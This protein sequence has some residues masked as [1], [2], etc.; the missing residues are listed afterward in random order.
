MKRFLL[1]LCAG[2]MGI[3]CGIIMENMGTVLGATDMN[4]VDISATRYISETVEMSGN[5]CTDL[6]S[7]EDVFVIENGGELRLKDVTLSSKVDTKLGNVFLV[8][9]GGVLVLENVTLDISIKANY[10]IR[11]EGCIELDNVNFPSGITRS[12]YNLSN[13]ESSFKLITAYFA[14]GVELAKGY[15]SVL[16]TTQITSDIN[17][18][19]WSGDEGL[20]LKGYGKNV[21]AN[22]YIDYINIV[23]LDGDNFRLDYIAD[24]V[25]EDAKDKQ[26]NILSAGDIV[27]VSHTDVD[28][29][30]NKS[31]KLQDGYCTANYLYNNLE[32]KSM[33]ISNYNSTIYLNNFECIKSG[34]YFLK[35]PGEVNLTIYTTVEGNNV[36]SKKYTYAS[37]L[38]WAVFVDIPEGYSAEHMEVCI[39]G[40]GLKVSEDKYANSR[41]LRPVIE[42]ASDGEEYITVDITFNFKTP[43][44]VGNICIEKENNVE[45]EYSDI[46]VGESQTFTITKSEDCN[47][48][49]V[50]FN[51]SEIECSIDGNKYIFTS[52]ASRENTLQILSVTNV[53]IVPETMELYYGEDILLGRNYLVS[54][55]GE[56]I[57]IQ[58]IGD[59]NMSAGVHRITGVV[60]NN[61]KYNVSLADGEYTY[62]INPKEISIKDIPY[63]NCIEREYDENLR[64]SSEMFVE[65]P[66]YI[67]CTATLV[68]NT[69]TLGKQDVLLTFAVRDTNYTLKEQNT[70]VT[71]TLVITPKSID[72]NHCTFACL[73]FEYS[74]A[75]HSVRV[76]GLDDGLTAQISYG[77][78][79]P[80]DAGDYA[81]T[82]VITATNNLYSC[83]KTLTGIMHIRQKTVAISLVDRDIEYTGSIPHLECNVD[84]VVNG[85]SVEVLLEGIS[86]IDVEDYKVNVL[87]L[88]NANYCTDIE[89][90]EYSII[91]ADIDMTSVKFTDVSTEYDGK[92]H[93]PVLAG[94]LP[95]GI[96]AYVEERECIDADTY[97]VA[98]TFVTNKNYTT[99]DTMYARVEISPR[100]I[101]VVFE[102]PDNLVFDGTKKEVYISFTRTLTPNIQ[103][104][105]SYSGDCILAGTY[106]CTVTLPQNSNYKIVSPNT[107]TFAIYSPR[108]SYV[109]EEINFVVEGK[110]HPDRAVNILDTTSSLKT[111]GMVADMP[112]RNYTGI[113]V[114]CEDTQLMQVT[115]RTYKVSNYSNLRLYTINNG[116]LELIDY[117][118]EN[119]TIHFSITGSQ[120]ILLVELKDKSPILK[121]LL[122]SLSVL[123]LSSVVAI[124]IV[125]SKKKRRVVEKFIEVEE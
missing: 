116:K 92:N 17:I 85:D 55:T 111:A 102:E 53:T 27:I 24:D 32:D 103:Y 81:V 101:S 84:G 4:E 113:E 52:V 57:N 65:L 49:K 6:Q 109:S 48:L 59:G 76:L 58:Y 37:M 88:S 12:V 118:L 21:F 124:C 9:S 117:T 1:G 73:D 121:I 50:I 91:P 98:C 62:V 8:K 86:S 47:I 79:T 100:E 82:A 125:R 38:D 10:G 75:Q 66:E 94:T 96:T 105:V 36:S 69:L 93:L 97:I 95:T 67:S 31:T 46:Y 19:N 16:E 42:Y 33:S 83:N 44:E 119:D 108:S 107:H 78:K 23:G 51:G 14:G 64:V 35:S 87:G 68:N 45:V 3:Y 13:E 25:P 90:L 40:D 70:T 77:D 20:I 43:R 28:L 7:G 99:P 123:I 54:S 15:I 72:A 106:T 39:K 71:V 74:G 29:N 11:N 34:S 122:I 5:I 115:I 61:L 60:C 104:T 26:G 41:Y 120:N 18:Y 114:T 30:L 22:K 63:A 112:I 56:E 89:E 2:I 110:F 80:I